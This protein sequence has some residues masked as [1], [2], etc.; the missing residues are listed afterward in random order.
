[1]F[2]SLIFFVQKTCESALNIKKNKCLFWNIYG[3]TL[4]IYV[5]TLPNKKK[6]VLDYLPIKGIEIVI[7]SHIGIFD[8]LQS[9]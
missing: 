3:V 1:M 7:T 4:K 6:A 5:V 8:R 9:S 2:T